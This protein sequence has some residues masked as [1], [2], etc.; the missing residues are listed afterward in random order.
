MSPLD[1]SDLYRI[2]ESLDR[3]NDG[4]LSLDE[5]NWLLESTGA[6]DATLYELVE[7]FGKTSLNFEEFSEFHNFVFMEIRTEV[8]SYKDSID[9][10]KYDIIGEHEKDDDD[11]ESDLYKAFRVFDLNGDGLISS[12]E[13]QSVLCKLGT[14]DKNCALDCDKIIQKYDVNSD[15]FVDFDEFK[16]MMLTH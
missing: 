15:G 14:S 12:K 7:L 11:K 5:L 4:L 6:H 8:E 16:M 9:T 3:N 13:L 1:T 2:F 10:Y